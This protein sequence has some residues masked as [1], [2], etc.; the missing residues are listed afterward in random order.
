MNTPITACQYIPQAATVILTREHA[1]QLQVYLLKRSL[2]SGFM[3]G[4][5]VFPGG[6]V[7]VED[8]HFNI[9]KDRSDLSINMIVSR[10]GGVLSGAQT[11][12]FCVAAIRETLEEAGILLAQRDDELEANL[13][14]LHR[15]RIAG[16]LKKDW[17]TRFV[18]NSNWRLTLSALSR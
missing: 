5:F 3:A 2:K 18:A 1:G 7:E 12:A 6:T 11:L 10:L 9:F 14:R 15:L 13:E 16:N 8:R 4:N 17:F